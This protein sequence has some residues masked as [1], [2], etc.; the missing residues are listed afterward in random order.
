MQVR[1]YRTKNWFFVHTTVIWDYGKVIGPVGIAVY[2]L[3]ASR[4]DNNTQDC[5][6]SQQSI[7]ESI[8]SSESSVHRAVSQ[9][10]ELGLI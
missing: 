4:A 7:A 10:E 8:G 2:N 6:P 1:D 3:L 9:L 5:Y